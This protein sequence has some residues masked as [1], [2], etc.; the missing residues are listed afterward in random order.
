MSS[1]AA[2]VLYTDAFYLQT[3]LFWRLQRA[4][5]RDRG[6]LSVFACGGHGGVQILRAAAP[7]DGT[8]GQLLSDLS[9][10][11]TGQIQALS[12]LGA[13][14]YRDFNCP[15]K[16]RRAKTLGEGALDTHIA[17]A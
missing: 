13:V 7:N 3:V 4:G 14:Y 9:G 12:D 5:R 6:H 2:S 15:P 10:L 1:E 16:W 11:P 17:K 8:L